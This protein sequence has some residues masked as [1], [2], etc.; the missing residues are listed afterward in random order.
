MTEIPPKARSYMTE[1]PYNMLE[2]SRVL[3]LSINVQ[4][5]IGIKKYKKENNIHGL[6]STVMP[7]P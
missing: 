4:R 1:A 7:I 6:H 5:I 3:N 2:Q